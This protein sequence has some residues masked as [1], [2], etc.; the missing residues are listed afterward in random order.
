M[1]VDDET[2]LRADPEIVADWVAGWALSRGVAPPTDAYGGLYVDVGLP[3]QKAR[4]VFAAPSEGVKEA[5]R[6]I[7]DP[8]VF[9]KVCAPPDMVRGLLAAGWEV[10]PLSFMMVVPRLGPDG[11]DPR[12]GYEASQEL[13][14]AGAAVTIRTA[15]GETAASG[16]VAF[17]GPTAVFDRI[18]TH[19]DHRRRG[20][21][22]I[23]M[24]RL[25]A[26]AHRAGRTRGALVATPDGRA[27]YSAMGWELHSLYTTAVRP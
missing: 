11:E 4:Y 19:P 6:S 20:L 10:Q 12:G 5:A 22:R 14:T 8:H 24:S 2:A 1:T 21:G 26:I 13:V 17:A 18:V 25:G 27:L 15:D 7:T 23:V 9:L 3:N 16:H